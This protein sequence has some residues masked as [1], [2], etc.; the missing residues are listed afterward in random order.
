MTKHTRNDESYLSPMNIIKRKSNQVD[1]FV[2]NASSETRNGA[3]I[4]VTEKYISIQ[5]ARSS[6]L[7]QKK[8]SKV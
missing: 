8:A 7:A 5:I 4:G 2:V 3:T 1:Q 6:K